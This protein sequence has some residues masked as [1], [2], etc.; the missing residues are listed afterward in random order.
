MPL[1]G[2][3]Y[4]RVS[5]LGTQNRRPYFYERGWASRGPRT[6]AET[7]VRD[8]ASYVSSRGRRFVVTSALREDQRSRSIRA[9]RR[10]CKGDALTVPDRRTPPDR[11]CSGRAR[12]RRAQPRRGRIRLARVV[13]DRDLP[14]HR[15]HV[16]EPP[17]LHRPFKPGV[18]LALLNGV[19]AAWAHDGRSRRRQSRA[20]AA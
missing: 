9:P 1:I 19:G 14:R 16:R 5:G 12:C 15:P 10:R 18:R 6:R 13:R 4:V 8:R 17:W 11:R 20:R 7:G 2:G 3:I